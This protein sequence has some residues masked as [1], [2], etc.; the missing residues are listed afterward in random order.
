MNPAA[1]D[2]EVQHLR[3]RR[4]GDGKGGRTQAFDDGGVRQA[5]IRRATDRDQEHLEGGRR[6]GRTE[7]IAYVVDT[8]REIARGDRLKFRELVAEVQTVSRPPAHRVT[9]PA[10]IALREITPGR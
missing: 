1:L 9:H 7:W 6:A 2:E 3:K 10:R 5:R 8:D 4:K